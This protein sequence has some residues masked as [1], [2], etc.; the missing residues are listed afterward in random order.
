M[1]RRLMGLGIGAMFSLWSVAEEL[2]A[3]SKN[4]SSPLGGEV[5]QHQQETL[6]LQSL[7]ISPNRQLAQINGHL[8]RLGE[9]LGIYELIEL[10]KEGVTLRAGDREVVLK[11]RKSA[12]KTKITLR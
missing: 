7:L 1:I 5:R 6:V 4:P 2:P 8:L 10:N 9:K 11:A 12:A 3:I